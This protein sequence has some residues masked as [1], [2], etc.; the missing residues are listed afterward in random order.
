MEFLNDGAQFEGLTKR[1]SARKVCE[2][3][4]GFQSPISGSPVRFSPRTVLSQEISAFTLTHMGGEASFRVSFLSVNKPVSLALS[5]SLPPLLLSPL[6]LLVIAVLHQALRAT[7]TTLQ[8]MGPP[9]L[10]GEDK[11]HPE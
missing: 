7:Q 9:S 3:A 6:L 8:P 10:S 4:S 5:S 11:P 2:V 1:W